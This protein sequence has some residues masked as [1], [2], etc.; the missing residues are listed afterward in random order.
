M[1]PKLKLLTLQLWPRLKELAHRADRACAAVPFF[2]Q[3]GAQRLPLKDGDLL[4]TRFDDSAIKSGVTDPREILKLVK[5]GVSVHSV[6]NLHAKVYVFGESAIVGSANVSALSERLVEA[7]VESNDEIV[8]RA[9]RQWIE[10]LTG[11]VIE[12]E[13]AEAKIPLYR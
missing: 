8:V 1:A 9:C 2:S 12:P 5:R 13:Y 6:S 10:S 4:V 7:A 11:D 3:G